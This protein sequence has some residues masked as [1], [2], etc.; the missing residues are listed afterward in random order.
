MSFVSCLLIAD[1]FA[2]EQLAV[3]IQYLGVRTQLHFL[4]I[5]QNTL[6]SVQLG[7]CQLYKDRYLTQ[8][9]L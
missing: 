7:L 2:L 1:Q 3:Q 8:Q 4:F 6:Y 9:N 5:S